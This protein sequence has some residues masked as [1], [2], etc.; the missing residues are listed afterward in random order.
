MSLKIAIFKGQGRV[1]F[2]IDLLKNE[3]FLHIKVLGKYQ[4]KN[5]LQ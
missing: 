2:G 4:E 1:A 3:L 5:F